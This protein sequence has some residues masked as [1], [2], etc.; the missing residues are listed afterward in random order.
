LA[1]I[2]KSQR[3]SIILCSNHTNCRLGANSFLTSPFIYDIGQGTEFSEFLFLAVLGLHGTMAAGGKQQTINIGT[4]P[5]E[6]LNG[7]REQLQEEDRFLTNS[8]S[9]LRVAQVSFFRFQ[10]IEFFCKFFPKLALV[11]S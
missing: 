1:E 9:Q 7:L 4:M 11:E 10:K 6:Q 8:Y 3:R 2:L 5:L